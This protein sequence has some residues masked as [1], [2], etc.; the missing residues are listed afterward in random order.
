MQEFIGIGGILTTIFATIATCVVTW[1]VAQKGNKVKR[2][3]YKIKTEMVLSKGA[4]NSKNN[5]KI[6]YE[7][8]LIAEPYILSIYVSNTGNRAI[9][10]P[11]ITVKI[12][13]S[14]FITPVEI[15]DIPD[16]YEKMWDIG[17]LN[18][19][20]CYIKLEH[21]NPKQHI[22]AKF[23]IDGT[24]DNVV[25][26]CCPMEDVEIIRIEDAISKRATRITGISLSGF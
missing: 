20:E 18:S 17:I 16:G 13:N 12:K 11:P 5:L 2:I 24:P 23:Y 4:N 6:F 9:L 7:D 15:D 22:V 19:N 21:I 26:F 8:K 14:V 3:S 10:N 1:L 25:Q